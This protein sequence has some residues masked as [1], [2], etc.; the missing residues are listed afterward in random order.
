MKTYD[1][2]NNKLKEIKIED[3]I[4]IIYIGIIILSFY[5]NSL[6]KKYF[7]YNDLLSKEKYRKILIFIFSILIVVY[8]YFLKDSYDSLNDLKLNDS[9]KKK[10]LTYLSFIGSLLIAISGFIFLYIALNDEDL[11][12]ELA[13]NWRNL[14]FKRK[15]LE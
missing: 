11:D 13:F 14:T 10:N 2:I 12:V 7:L 6:E 5:S 3:F 1:E 8:L 9:D 15:F 4:W